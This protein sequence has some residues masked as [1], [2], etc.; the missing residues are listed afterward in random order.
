L[1]SNTFNHEQTVPKPDEVFP[2]TLKDGAVTQIRRYAN[3][4][5]PCVALSHGNG[6]AIDAY[7]PFWEPLRKDFELCVFDQRHHGWNERPVSQKTGYYL[8]AEDMEQIFRALK[9]RY[10]EVPIYGAFHSVSAIAS[11]LQSATHE[12]LIEA[13]VLFDPPLQPPKDHHLYQQ[14]YDYEMKLSVWSKTRQEKFSSPNELAEQFS[15]SRSLSDWADGAHDLMAHSILRESGDHWEIRCLPAIESQ[16]YIDSA[17][18]LIWELLSAPK[19]PVAIVYG[20]PNHPAKMAPASVCEDFVQE[21]GIPHRSIKD[22]THL[23]QVEKPDACREAFY[24]LLN[25]LV[26]KL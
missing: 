17:E 15:K 21:F 12:T 8:F 4:G 13:L 23:L 20:D 2:V 6:F 18:L 22:T 10:P 3:P 26:G 14:A 19:M 5:K 16:I 25:E 9:S 11:F 24:E 7:A 1:N